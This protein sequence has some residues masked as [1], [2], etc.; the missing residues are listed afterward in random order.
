MKNSRMG[1]K[2]LFMLLLLILLSGLSMTFGDAKIGFSETYRIIIDNVKRLIGMSFDSHGTKDLIIMNIRLPRIITAIVVGA[3]LSAVGCSYQG[4]FKNPMAD[5]Y[6]LGISSGATLGAALVI[7]SFK[8]TTIPGISLIALAAFIGALSTTFLVYFI[9][10]K[11]KKV[12]TQSLLLSGIAISYF[13]SAIVSILMVINEKDVARIIYWTMG[14]LASTGYLQLVVMTPAIGIL[15]YLLWRYSGDLDILT[16]G[17][18][19]A[20]SM[21][22]E[23]SKVRQN[24]LII[25]SFI[26]AICVA[27]T[28]TIGFVGLIIPHIVRNIVGPAH[29]KLIPFSMVTG[30]IFL[31]FA[32]TVARSAIDGAQLPVGAVTAVFGAPFFIY[33]LMK[34]KR[35]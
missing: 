12:S 18:E 6:I 31:I 10:A 21:G 8:S 15:T 17:D 9:A 20:M 23:T 3:G 29:S 25:S 33:L 24:I 16:A 22:V 27:F 7:I 32:D 4:V 2:L 30:S 34:N 28:G 13:L 26:V 1:G 14:S 35:G 5:P 19:V 11:D